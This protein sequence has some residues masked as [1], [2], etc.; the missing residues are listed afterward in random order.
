LKAQILVINCGSS[1]IKFSLVEPEGGCHVLSGQAERLGAP[2]GFLRWKGAS[3]G[4]KSIG[5]VGHEEALLQIVGLLRDSGLAFDA[6]GHRVV[7]GGEH[8]S[9]SCLVN[10]ASVEALRAHQHLAPLHNPVNLLGI[11]AARHAF[12]ELPQVMVFDTAFHQSMPP[13]AY[14]Y[15]LPYNLYS[16]HGIRRYGFHGTSHRYVSAKTAETLGR[17]LE[18]LALITA[19]LGNG[20][21]AAAILGGKSLDTTMGMTPLE[22]LV[23]GTRSGD[24]DP[25]LHEHLCNTLNISLKEVSTL[26]NKQSGLFGLS[27]LTNDMRELLQAE[28][29]GHERAAIAVEVFCYR[30]AKHIAALMV[31]L[32]RLDA[33]VFTGGIGENSIPVRART[34]RLLPFLG[35]ELDEEANNLHGRN[36]RGIISRS[37]RPCAIV[38]PTDEELLI[39]RDTLTQIS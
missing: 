11:E 21:S 37:T 26:L 29:Q 32:G 12:P 13:R 39:A 5:A 9:A 35:L 6:I 27:G 38:T 1:S 28:A 14:L 2:D 24:I 23:M 8:F 22:G 33:L 15:P 18:D 3:Q 19:H 17:P 25:S 7:H 16:E 34:L 20:C 36:T 31:A 4:Q 10:D 30:L